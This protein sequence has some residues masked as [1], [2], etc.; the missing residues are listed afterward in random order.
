MEAFTRCKE[1]SGG[2]PGLSTSRIFTYS[3]LVQRSDRG[4][5]NS[6]LDA[7]FYTFEYFLDLRSPF[8]GSTHISA[9]RLP[10]A[11]SRRRLRSAFRTSNGIYYAKSLRVRVCEC[12]PRERAKQRGAVEKGAEVRSAAGGGVEGKKLAISSRRRPTRKSGST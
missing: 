6:H 5:R 12:V 11:T 2:P 10:S 8:F 3:S 7:F 4:A 9:G 1:L